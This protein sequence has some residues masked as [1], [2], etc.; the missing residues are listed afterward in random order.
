MD[1]IYLLRGTEIK[2]DQ[3][4]LVVVTE[5][6][7]KRRLPVEALRHVVVLGAT[8]L[9]SEVATFLGKHGVRLSFLDYYGHFSGSLEPAR[10]HHSGSVHLA[11]AKMILNDASRLTMAS[12]IL[13]AGA[14]N[15]LRNLKYYLYR[16]NHDLKKPIHFL[17]Q[18]LSTKRADSIE[19]LMG[20]E[21]SFRKNYYAAW[22]KINPALTILK[23]T[24]RP[25][26][27]RINSLLSFCNG[28]IYSACSQAIAQTHLDP[29]LSFIHAPTQARNS[30]ALDLAEVFKPLVA[31]RVIFSMINKEML[32]DCCYQEEAGVCLLNPN[33]RER[34]LRE[35]RERMDNTKIAGEVGWRR[36]FL[37]EAFAIE[38]HLLELSEYEPFMVKA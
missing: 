18:Q 27:D 30:L 20:Q 29:T 23:R 17:E 6:R 33:G 8:R 38:A 3:N 14:C 7:Q 26:T 19:G 24:R 22:G 36:I 2:R 11:Q 21:G 12:R 34:V 1:T 31:D 4:T 35:F 16:G 15:M 5:D 9:N 25:P 32:D 28:L 37:K 13:E 10:H